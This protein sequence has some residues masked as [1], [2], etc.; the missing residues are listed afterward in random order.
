KLKTGNETFP[1][2]RDETSTLDATSKEERENTALTSKE[3]RSDLP[4][5]S[6]EES[7]FE[8]QWPNVW[9]AKMWV[10]KKKVYSWLTCKRGRIGC[11]SCAAVKKLGPTKTQG[12]SISNEWCSVLVTYYGDNGSTQLTSLRKK[13][14][15]H[16]KSTS[17]IQSENILQVG[18]EQQ[19][20][21]IVDQMNDEEISGTSKIF[22]TAYS[23][24]KHD[25][26]CSDQFDLLRLQELNETA[27]SHGLRSRFSATNII[28]HVFKETKNKLCRQIKSLG[29]K[30]SILIDENSN[31]NKTEQSMF[32][33][34][35]SESPS[36]IDCD[37]G[38]KEIKF[39]CKC[40]NLSVTKCLNAYKDY[41]ANGD[42]NV[43]KDLEDLQICAKMVACSSSE[44]ERDF[45]SMNV[46][47]KEKRSR[48]LIQ[49]VSSLLF[50]KLHGPPVEL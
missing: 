21:H 32:T 12:V 13:I 50:I 11:L 44:C 14:F 27:I 28:E 7:E 2:D 34:L 24:A 15:T 45:S 16:A 19:L 40:F 47:P 22:R 39:L 46:I 38:S 18:S 41:V 1:K 26:P 35:P 5:T 3:K 37:Y 4:L 29:G 31:R 8:F 43:P 17:H 20:E 23:I 49:H 33:G 42:R 25:R 48:I 9:N 30:L 36:E 6:K 10:E